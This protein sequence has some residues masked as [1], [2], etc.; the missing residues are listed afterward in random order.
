ML[1]SDLFDGKCGLFPLLNDECSLREPNHLNFL[2]N[3]QAQCK[4][5]SF[6][7]L[8]KSDCFTIKH[9]VS[10]VKYS[11]VNEIKT[12]HFISVNIE[13]LKEFFSFLH[14][15]TLLKKTAEFQT[16]NSIIF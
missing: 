12:P 8:A 2:T 9:H 6:S 13:F 5:L 4:Y 15:K 14:R 1:F 10:P 16:N 7:M 11:T 3:L